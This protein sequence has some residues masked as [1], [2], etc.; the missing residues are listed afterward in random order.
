MSALLAL[1]GNTRRRNANRVVE[2]EQ[3]HTALV[4]AIADGDS[5]ARRPAPADTSRPHSETC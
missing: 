4:A 1:V 5:H 2:A 3:E